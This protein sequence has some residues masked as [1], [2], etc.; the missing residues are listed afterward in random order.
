MKNFWKHKKV[1]VTGGAGFIGSNAVKELAKRHSVVTIAVSKSTS[2][3]ELK[4]I[5]GGL[6]KEINICFIDLLSINDCLR[7]TKGMDVVLNFAA[8]DGGTKFKKEHATEIYKVNTEIVKNVLKAAE[9]N[10]VDRVLL[11]SSIDVYPKGTDAVLNEADADTITS[12]GYVGAKIFSEKLAKKYYD[13]Y[14]LKIAIAR[15]GN[16]YGPGDTFSKGRARVI[17][18]FIAKALKGENIEISVNLSRKL[19]FIHV[20]DLVAALLNLTGN[21]ANCDPVNIL[22]S[23][24]ISL[25]ELAKTIIT[26]VNSNSKII[27]SK[28]V[29]EKKNP[30]ISVSKARR[31][32]DFKERVG[33][34]NGLKVLIGV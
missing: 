29:V 25:E 22:G 10:K 33:F 6:L 26:V 23:E 34:K 16:V 28:N 15:P 32:I 27:L 1:L 13:K 8:M 24:K 11:M 2:Q 7:I 20:T 3:S 17:P 9:Q 5:F 12:K 31:V 21:Y 4:K 30:I 19:A 18:T 14:G